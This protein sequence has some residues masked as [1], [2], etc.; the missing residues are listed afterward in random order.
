LYLTAIGDARLSIIYTS[1]NFLCFFIAVSLTKTNKKGLAL[2]QHIIED[3]R[4]CVEKYSTVFLFSVHNMRNNKL[5]EIKTQWTGSRFFF[6]KNKIVAL[7]FGKTPETEITD[8]ISELS[9]K[10]SGQCGLFFTNE[11][12]NKVRLFHM[13]NSSVFQDAFKMRQPKG[14]IKYTFNH[15][16]F[17][18][19]YFSLDFRS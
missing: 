1:Y 7:A 19:K 9:A 13:M 16:N 5:K 2:K 4:A 8:G 6:G 17:F 12:K 11:N 15:N 10:L 14:T 3:V 18:H